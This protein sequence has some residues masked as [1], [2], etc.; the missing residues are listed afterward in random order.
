MCLFRVGMRDWQGKQ[1]GI[2][3][4][5]HYTVTSS[6]LT[7]AKAEAS[8]N[9]PFVHI[10]VSGFIFMNSRTKQRLCTLSGPVKCIHYHLPLV[11]IRPYEV[12]C[13]GLRHKRHLP[14][15]G[16][17]VCR[18]SVLLTS[19]SSASPQSRSLFFQPFYER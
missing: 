5:N 12:F 13:V 10:A 9:E 1:S 14:I 4:I 2:R 19:V 16:I 11:S 15:S 6:S 8:E 3:D 17:C 7:N 18:V